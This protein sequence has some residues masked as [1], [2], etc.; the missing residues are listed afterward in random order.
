MSA[1]VHPNRILRSPA[2]KDFHESKC[3]STSSIESETLA[4][5]KSFIHTVKRRRSDEARTTL[6]ILKSSVSGENVS[7]HGAATCLAKK[8]GIKRANIKSVGIIPERTLVIV[9]YREF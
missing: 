6:T 8:L 7:I 1:Y 3:V 4:E 2:V 9:K 5:I